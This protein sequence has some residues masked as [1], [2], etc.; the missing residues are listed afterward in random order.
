MSRVATRRSLPRMWGVAPAGISIDGLLASDLP[1][2]ALLLLTDVV[3]VGLLIRIR[4][5]RVRLAAANAWTEPL[6]LLTLRARMRIEDDAPARTHLPQTRELLD[7]LHRRQ[8]ADR[9][10]PVSGV[11]GSARRR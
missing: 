1:L 7:E 10:A 5:R 4:R 3:G 8:S 2:Y 6:D 9:A 11:A